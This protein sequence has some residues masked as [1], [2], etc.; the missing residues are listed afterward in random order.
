M[1]VPQPISVMIPKT[2]EGYRG[3]FFGLLLSV[4][5]NAAGIAVGMAVLVA[6]G[7]GMIFAPHFQTLEDQDRDESKRVRDSDRFFGRN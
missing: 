2:P 6:F 3:A 1:K 5:V 4:A 7:A